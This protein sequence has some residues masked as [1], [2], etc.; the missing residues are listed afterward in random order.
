VQI[1]GQSEIGNLQ[2]IAVRYEH[3]ASSKITVQALERKYELIS[4]S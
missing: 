3:V 1:F 4:F 2:F